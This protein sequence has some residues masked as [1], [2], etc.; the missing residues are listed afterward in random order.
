M[1]TATA[2]AVGKWMN[3]A[4]LAASWGGAA[5]VIA[6]SL[7]VVY[8]SSLGER[9]LTNWLWTLGWTLFAVG[10]VVQVILLLRSLS[11]EPIIPKTNDGALP[12]QLTELNERGRQYGAQL[13]QIPFAYVG[14]VGAVMSQVGD[15]PALLTPT[16]LGASIFG[17]PVL[18]HAVTMLEGNRRAV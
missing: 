1:K 18:L 13:W 14:I 4:A 6:A 11:D 2:N 3:R 12:A 16:L 17:I 10:V 8:A 7:A 15:K 9:S 5:L